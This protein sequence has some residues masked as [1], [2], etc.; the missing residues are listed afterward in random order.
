VASAVNNAVA[1]AAGLVAVAILPPLAGLTGDAYLDPVAFS[2]GFHRA[3][4]IAALLTA[5]G[6][7]VGWIML[8]ER[9]PTARKYSDGYSCAIDA[10][11]LRVSE[12]GSS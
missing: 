12:S 7:V 2:T 11:P 5:I 8:G 1:R 10:P 4:L 3:V 6:G 9:P